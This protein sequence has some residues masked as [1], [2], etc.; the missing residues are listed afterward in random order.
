MLYQFIIKVCR[1]KDLK[2]SP[3]TQIILETIFKSFNLDFNLVATRQYF[4]EKTLEV[5]KS[6]FLEERDKYLM[7]L[8]VNNIKDIASVV[9]MI[10]IQYK[11]YDLS[12]NKHLMT[13]IESNIKK[14]LRLISQ[15]DKL[16]DQ[17]K[18]RRK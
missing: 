4:Y 3:S 18:S 2:V 11:K 5:V 9:E 6:S 10:Y 7:K 15:I 16:I 8:L 14:L 1:D 13:N 12:K 17:I